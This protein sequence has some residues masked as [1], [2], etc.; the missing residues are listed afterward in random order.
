MLHPKW[1]LRTDD[2]K[3]PAA[4]FALQSALTTRTATCDHASPRS[5]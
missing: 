3:P 4:R 5:C 2:G 1:H